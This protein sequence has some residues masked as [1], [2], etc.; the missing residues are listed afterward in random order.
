L[1]FLPPGFA[2]QAFGARDAFAVANY[3]ELRAVGETDATL[4][5][6]AL[7]ARNG[8]RPTRCVILKLADGS[9]VFAGCAS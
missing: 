5:T 6:Q 9:Y 7:D 2:Q 8:T 3:P 1:D 4:A